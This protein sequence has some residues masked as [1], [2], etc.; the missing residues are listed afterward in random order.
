MSCLAQDLLHHCELAWCQLLLEPARCAQELRVVPL[1]HRLL[2]RLVLRM[3]L[4]LAR[5]LLLNSRDAAGTSG[6][7]MWGGG[8]LIL[9]VLWEGEKSTSACVLL[10]LTCLLPAVVTHGSCV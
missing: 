4:A 8:G 3:Q 10:V 6:K 9:S 1:P 7:F 2:S 5:A